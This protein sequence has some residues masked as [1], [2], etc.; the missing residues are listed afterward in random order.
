MR[1]RGVLAPLSLATA[2]PL[3][4]HVLV[5]TCGFRIILAQ[6]QLVA[7]LTNN[8]QA[9][10]LQPQPAPQQDGSSQARPPR[11]APSEQERRRRADPAYV[12]Q[13]MNP[14][15]LNPNELPFATSLL[16][17]PSSVSAAKA[18]GGAASVR[19]ADDED[20]GE[21]EEAQAHLHTYT[22]T[23]L[24][25]V[26]VA[27]LKRSTKLHSAK[28]LQ[29]QLL[30]TQTQTQLATSSPTPADKPWG[31]SQTRSIVN[32]TYALKTILGQSSVPALQQPRRYEIATVQRQARQ[33]ALQKEQ[34]LHGQG[35]GH[36][37]GHGHGASKSQRSEESKRND[38]KKVSSDA[39]YPRVDY[40]TNTST[41][42]P[43]RRH[44][45]VAKLYAKMHR[46]LD[47]IDQTAQQQQPLAGQGSYR[48]HSG[49]GSQGGLPRLSG[50]HGHYSHVDWQQER[51]RQHRVV[52]K[53]QEQ[54]QQL[55]QAV[56]TVSTELPEAQ[57]KR[58]EKER[59]LR[60]GHISILKK[61]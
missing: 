58:E 25:G 14:S 31:M 46:V 8:K 6:P 28:L 18:K 33:L 1:S 21:E 36:G 42:S 49:G 19:A 7:T 47:L 35:H 30:Q 12:W 39:A 40:F 37:H 44:A 16:S 5:Q 53:E 23:F 57:R 60:N 20:A 26:N 22:D 32:S 27:E 15:T 38:K 51:A 59:E 34:L 43:E 24:T 13:H 55:L 52:E 56:A 29:Q 54:V 41:I 17:P 9:H 4:Q 11:A 45:S 10:I 2:F 50:P 61:R 48:P 3:L